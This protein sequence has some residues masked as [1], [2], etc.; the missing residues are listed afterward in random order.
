[1]YNNN[2]KLERIQI[3]FV[4]LILIESVKYPR[5]FVGKYYFLAELVIFKYR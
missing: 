2:V 5:N 1:M 4:H 3:N